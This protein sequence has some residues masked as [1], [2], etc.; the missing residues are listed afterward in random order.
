MLGIIILIDPASITVVSEITVTIVTGTPM[1]DSMVCKYTN[2]LP[3]NHHTRRVIFSTSKIQKS[4]SFITGRVRTDFI[5]TYNEPVQLAFLYPFCITL[6][7]TT[8]VLVTKRSLL[9]KIINH[10]FT[11]ILF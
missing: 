7:N 4:L 10:Y 1:V 2:T 11:S 8:K 3:K 9:E 6:L 5:L